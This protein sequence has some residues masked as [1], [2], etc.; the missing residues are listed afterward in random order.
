MTLAIALCAAADALDANAEELTRL[1]AIAGDGDLGVTAAKVAHALREA[2]AGQ[3]VNAAEL[4]GQS[5]RN[6][7]LSAASSCGTLLASA[8][9]AASKSVDTGTVPQQLAAGLG[10]AMD[11]VMKRGKAAVGDRTLLDALAPAVT[12]AQEHEESLLEC[13]KAVSSAVNAGMESTKSMVPRI[14]RA[15][16]QPERASGN[17]DAGAVLVAVALTAG[18]NAALREGKP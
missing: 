1:D 3:H 5:G 4:L 12:A 2:V 15:R 10:A 18:L 9:L 16:T 8:L 13:F 14:G 7:A 11:A 17:P 6:I